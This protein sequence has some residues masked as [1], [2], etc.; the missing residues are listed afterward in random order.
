MLKNSENHG[1]SWSKSSLIHSTKKMIEFQND[2][3]CITSGGEKYLIFWRMFTGAYLDVLREVPGQGV[4]QDMGVVPDSHDRS[5]HDRVGFAAGTGG[6]LAA[7]FITE[8]GDVRVFQSINSG[9]GWEELTDLIL[10]DDPGKKY[11]ARNSNP[12][13]GKLP[14]GW[15]ITWQHKVVK[16]VN[17]KT[18][19]EYID[20]LFASYK[21]SAKQWSVPVYVN[22]NRALVQKE[23]RQEKSLCNLMPAGLE[24]FFDFNEDRVTPH[25]ILCISETGRMAVVWIEPVDG[26]YTGALSF[27][28][29]GGNSWSES[30]PILSTHTGSFK[31]IHAKFGAGGKYIY[32]IYLQNPGSDQKSNIKI[33]KI[34]ISKD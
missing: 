20:I 4:W 15:G 6:R 30:A 18:G 7:A 31:S 29:D 16:N 19:E 14:Q 8:N 12:F 28:D 3:F 33:A 23:S 13:I 32:A 1:K 34:N 27:S 26:W 17:I 10:P 5:Y 24:E 9:I 22:D 2:S 25:A 21:E 11:D